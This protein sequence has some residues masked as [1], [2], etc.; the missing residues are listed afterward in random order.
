[1]REQKVRLTYKGKKFKL[2]L[3]VCSE[4]G[5]VSGLMFTRRERAKPLLFNFKKLNKIKI[6][7][8]FVFFPFIAIWLDD[9]NKIID[10]KLVKPFTF[11]IGPKE[12]FKKLIEIPINSKNQEIV[13]ILVGKAKI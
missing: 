12:T 10:L 6:H 8:W 5:K 4:L 2:K 11:T 3:N 9:K 13:K 1:M 7:S